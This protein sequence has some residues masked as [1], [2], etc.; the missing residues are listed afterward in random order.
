[1]LD[2]VSTEK[3]LDCNSHF[4][5]N[6]RCINEAAQNIGGKALIVGM[7]TANDIDL[8]FLSE[9]FEKIIAL[10][11]DKESMNE[12]VEK[13]AEDVQPKFDIATIF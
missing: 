2:K 5:I 3:N 4:Q 12:P 8:K 9:K 7:G 6:K 10:D 13:L 11:I 1:M